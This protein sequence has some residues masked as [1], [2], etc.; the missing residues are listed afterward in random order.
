MSRSPRATFWRRSFIAVGGMLLVG[1][2]AA[3]VMFPIQ[4]QA[5]ALLRGPL[6]RSL[7]RAV[8]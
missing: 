3:W 5:F 6:R 2:A 1:A 4:Y 8:L 7:S